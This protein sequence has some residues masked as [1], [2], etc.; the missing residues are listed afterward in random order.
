VAQPG[1]ATHIIDQC[2]VVQ[3][4]CRI[5]PTVVEQIVD[6]Y[7]DGACRGNPGPG[8]WGALLR[9]GEHE[10]ELCG[11]VAEDTTN[12]RME[13]TAPAEA[14]ESLTRS[15]VVRLHTDSTYV[16]NGITAWVPRWK[17]NGWTTSAKQPVKNVDLWQRLDAAVTRHQVE[18]FWVKGH[19]GHVENERA[20][21]LAAKGLDEAVAAAV[22]VG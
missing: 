4:H 5:L 6:V 13:L 3:A 14:L 10:R 8:G 15:C 7:T 19:S 1:S 18:W 20:D 21:R 12:N 17:R 22:N 11:G 2:T 9:Y 16:K